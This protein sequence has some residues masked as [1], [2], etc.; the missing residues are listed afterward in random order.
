MADRPSGGRKESI[1]RNIIEQIE[2][3]GYKV[4][5]G[6]TDYTQ[7]EER[8]DNYGTY[9]PYHIN[10]GHLCVKKPDGKVVNITGALSEKFQIGGIETTREELIKELYKPTDEEWFIFQHGYSTETEEKFKFLCNDH[11]LLKYTIDDPDHVNEKPEYDKKEPIK[12]P[13]INAEDEM[14]FYIGDEY[15][16]ELTVRAD[17]DSWVVYRYWFDKVPN[18]EDITFAYNISQIK[19]KLKCRLITEE[20]AIEK[21]RHSN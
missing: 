8:I 4:Y 21:L 16:V 5:K 3:L 1:M 10:Y 20:D 6:S 18:N 19:L 12:T 7:S 15:M 14:L 2:D 11:G 17:A 13:F 9:N